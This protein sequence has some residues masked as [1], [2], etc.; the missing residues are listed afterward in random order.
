[1]TRQ[2][3]Q[4]G[5]ALIA[6]LWSLLLIGLLVAF[7]IRVGRDDT[8]VSQNVLHQA[9]ARAA[10][11]AGVSL[12]LAGAL[13]QH[14]ASDWQTD[15]T[16]QQ[17]Q[18][19]DTMLT[20]RIYDENGKIDING[21]QQDKLRQLFAAAGETDDRAKEIAEHVVE[22]RTPA[23][24]GS[25][26]ATGSASDQSDRPRGGPF[27]SVDEIRLVRGVTS[28]LFGAVASLLTVYS[29]G[30]QVDLSVASP[31]VRQALQGMSPQ[32]LD[33]EG[34]SRPTFASIPALAGRVFTIQ[35]SALASSGAVYR[36]ETTIRF[37]NDRNKPFWTLAWRKSDWS[38]VTTV[39]R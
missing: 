12:A 6:V 3:Q 22:W 2:R 37:L 29:P 11:M 10:A 15:G 39:D 7:T 16:P 20:V 14:L 8:T 33:E 31:A 24:T 38:E 35:V 19:H 17:I 21:C 32:E 23:A 1:V 34:S 9:K 25:K 36:V 18:Y 30:C 4:E 28:D 5:F 26:N 27:E 13:D